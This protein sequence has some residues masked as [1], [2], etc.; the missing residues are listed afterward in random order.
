MIVTE[1]LANQT[2]DLPVGEV[3]EVRLEENPTT[4]FRWQLVSTGE[5]LDRSPPRRR[6]PTDQRAKQEK[7]DRTRRMGNRD[8]RPAVI[9]EELGLHRVEIRCGTGNLRS[10]A[11]PR[12][13]GFT[14]EGVAREAEWVN[15]SWV[16]LFVWWMLEA[17]WRRPRPR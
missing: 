15:D 7:R 9:D 10:C 16:D 5:L 2:I 17:D 1:K 6:L 13:L 11:I 12:R 4:G 8:E 14:S 3:V